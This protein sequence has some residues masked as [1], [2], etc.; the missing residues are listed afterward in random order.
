MPRARGMRPPASSLPAPIGA[1]RATLEGA[2]PDV[3]PLLLGAPSRGPQP[4]LSH[5][6]SSG[7][8][9]PAGHKQSTRPAGAPP[10]GPPHLCLQVFEQIKAQ[11]LTKQA[12]L[13]AK[14]AEFKAQAE[15]AA[16]VRAAAQSVWR[17]V[18]TAG[19][20]CSGSVGRVRRL[21]SGVC[22]AA[23]WV[24]FG[25]WALED[26]VR[27]A[28]WKADLVGARG[29]CAIAGGREEG[30]RLC[31]AACLRRAPPSCAA[32]R[33]LAHPPALPSTLVCQEHERVRWE[34]QRKA[35]QQDAQQKA[36]VAQYQDELARKRMESGE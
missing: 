32:L 29:G 33:C 3:R 6:C 14:E 21:C 23:G 36:Q 8:A 19:W 11:E 10:P 28:G 24:E 26:A 30:V 4:G 18:C 2:K 25:C 15:R 17:V 31:S 13:K 20:T 9:P 16:T 5:P 35:M 27:Q 22:A 7:C 1:A 12:E 34:E